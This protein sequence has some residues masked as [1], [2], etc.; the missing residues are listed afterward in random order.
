MSK[1]LYGISLQFKLD[2]RSKT[3]LITCYLVPLVFLMIMGQIFTS[4][5]PE[6]KS[7]LIQTMTIMG[8]SMGAIIGVPPSILE[9]YGTDIKKM[10]KSNG[11]PLYFGVVTLVISAFIHLL[12]L[13]VIIF[14]IANFVYLAVAPSNI[15][16][17]FIS[18]MI[19]ILV[20]LSVACVLGLSVKS[21]SKL[22]MISQIIFLPSIM[23]SGI[24]FEADLL[25]KSLQILGKI[26]PA[27]WGNIIMNSNSLYLNDILPLFIILVI[28][29]ILCT[30]IMK[31][32]SVE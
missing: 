3:L 31:R 22:T 25:P 1:L 17:Y 8:I 2:I 14:I 6:S 29:I 30:S 23:L 24:M 12:I 11:I 27:S 26:F 16:M 19:L 13:S 18:V 21:N 5:N 20:S 7:T 9:M 32:T 28:C 15:I 4:I 10:Y